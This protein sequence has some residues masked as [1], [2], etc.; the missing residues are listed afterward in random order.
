MSVVNSNMDI[1]QEILSEITVYNKY[2]KYIPELKRRESWKEI[3]ERN[4]AMHIKKF[5]A[6]K[7]EIQS[8]YK[9]FVFTKRS[10]IRNN[11]N[12]SR[13]VDRQTRNQRCFLEWGAY[14]WLI[15]R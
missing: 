12:Y 15:D 4:M 1:T 3:V 9:E 5:P 11:V 10:L 14:W 8:V 2:A 13:R 6:L 7:T